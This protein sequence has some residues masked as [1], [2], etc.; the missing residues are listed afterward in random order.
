MQLPAG[1]ERVVHHPVLYTDFILFNTLIPE[2]DPCAF[3]AS[4]YAMAISLLYGSNPNAAVFDLGADEDLA[5]F[6]LDSPP[7]GITVLGN[8]GIGQST[9]DQPE[10]I[11]SD[12]FAEYPDR[13]SW[14]ELK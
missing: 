10:F 11:Q 9:F 8:K 12:I 4:G 1:G 13:I 5:G 14:E 2:D 7:G 6:E 3:G